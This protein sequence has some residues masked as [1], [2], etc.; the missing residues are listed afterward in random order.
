M[1]RFSGSWDAKLERGSNEDWHRLEKGRVKIGGF[2][3]FA[4]FRGKDSD[5]ILQYRAQ[6][7]TPSE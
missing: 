4:P 1:E 3:I 5:Q 7:N 2:G 6:I